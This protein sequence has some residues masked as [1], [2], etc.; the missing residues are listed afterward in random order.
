[1]S[2]LASLLSIFRSSTGQYDMGRIISFKVSSIFS[3]AFGYAVFHNHQIINW[4]EAGAGFSAVLLGIGGL[5]AAPCSQGQFD[6]LVD[7]VFN[8]GPSQFLT[9]H[10]L[11]YHKA[12]EYDKAA[13]EFPKWKYDNGK[14]IRV[15]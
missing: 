10:L 12:G 4:T 8:V 15:W 11:K 3:A 5:I 9:S 7:F 13:A 1:M 6:A 2:K 14:V